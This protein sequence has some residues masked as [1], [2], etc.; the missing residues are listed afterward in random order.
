MSAF[1]HTNA[2]RNERPQLANNTS[3]HTNATLDQIAQALLAHDNYVIVGHVSPDGDCLGSQ[4]ALMHALHQLGKQARCVL[5]TDATSIDASFSFLPGITTMIAAATVAAA[6]KQASAPCVIALDV[7]S[8]DRMGKTAA[9][10][11]EQAQFTI[12]I[13]HHQ[14]D[15]ALSTLNYIDPN[16]ASTTLLVWQLL[17]ELG[18]QVTSDIALCTLTGLITDTGGFQYQNTNAFSL[19]CAAQML[20]A[21]ANLPFICT[22]VFQR[23][24]LAAMK[25]EN[26]ALD[27]FELLL[28]GQLAITYLT[29]HDFATVYAS[30]TDADNIINALRNIDG[31]RVACVLRESAEDALKEASEEASIRGSLRAKDATDVSVFAAQ[32]NGG[33]HKAAAGMTLHG[34][35][36][37][38]YE[39]IKQELTSYLLEAWKDRSV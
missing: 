11:H 34:N 7:P 38:V 23:R 30:K 28:N 1:S 19:R 17:A 18:V 32:H 22:Q 4:L 35:M 2:T 14:N 10:L 27:R 33:G 31:V 8:Y 26:I 6:N 39:N 24:S 15:K 36:Q 12:T 37:T 3:L 16:A 21:G 13:D 9:A 25:L 5:A 29:Q 20:E